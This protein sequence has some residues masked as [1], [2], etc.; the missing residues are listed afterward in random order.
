[1]GWV[2]SRIRLWRAGVLTGKYDPKDE[3]GERNAPVAAIS[4]FFKPSF[5]R[6]VGS[7]AADKEACRETRH[8]GRRF[9]HALGSE[10]QICHQRFGWTAD[11]GALERLFGCAEL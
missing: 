5:A 3:S 7:R 11:D 8:D 2:S 10:Q 4:E 1:M 6:I 9:R